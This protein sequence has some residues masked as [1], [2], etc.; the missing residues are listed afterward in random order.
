MARQFTVR[1]KNEP[2]A[3]AELAAA[4]AQH[5]IDIRSVAAGGV[6]AVGF[7]VLS[8][9]DDAAA[10][11]VL[12]KAKYAFVEGEVVGVAVEDQPGSLA[13]LTRR[14][15]DAGVNVE[16]VLVLGRRQGKAELAL[17]VDDL[18]KARY[19]LGT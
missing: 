2:G 13:R 16:S 18:E 5:G 10:R 19:L 12:R 9:N 3:L 17:T 8:T 14:L 11:E 4:L 15:A 7:A 1:L 6:G